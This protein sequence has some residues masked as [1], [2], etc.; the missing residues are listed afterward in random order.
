MTP[1]H[2]LLVIGFGSPLRLTLYVSGWSFRLYYDREHR[3]IFRVPRPRF[4]VFQN[5]VNKAS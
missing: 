2:V 1:D 5:H 3:V 4:A